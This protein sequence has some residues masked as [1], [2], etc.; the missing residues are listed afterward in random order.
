LISLVNFSTTASSRSLFTQSKRSPRRKMMTRMRMKSLARSARDLLRDHPEL[1]AW[2]LAIME[3]RMSRI[4]LRQIK[5][6]L[7]RKSSSLRQPRSQQPKPQPS[8]RKRR[9]RPSP[10]ASA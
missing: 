3:S 7:K 1:I 10:R 6:S 4:L 5:S 9:V 2:P 8:K